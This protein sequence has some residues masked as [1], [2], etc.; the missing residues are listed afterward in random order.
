MEHGGMQAICSLVMG[1]QLTCEKDIYECGWTN[2]QTHRDTLLT[3]LKI[4][5]L[6]NLV[7]RMTQ[8]LTIL[9]ILMQRFK[10]KL[11]M[12]AMVSIKQKN[13]KTSFRQNSSSQLCS[14]CHT[15]VEEC[16]LNP[17][18]PSIQVDEQLS[19]SVGNRTPH[20][21]PYIAKFWGDPLLWLSNS[22]LFDAAI[23]SNTSLNLL[24]LWRLEI[25]LSVSTL[26]D[27][28]VQFITGFQ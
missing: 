12:K 5:S 15:R 6:Q 10:H 16:N 13:T 9:S 4:V 8:K 19:Q 23:H 11:Q 21:S 14:M 3:K 24:L 26:Q 27:Y 18:I 17:E 1:S 22:D 2:S 25:N 20:S 28:L 7:K